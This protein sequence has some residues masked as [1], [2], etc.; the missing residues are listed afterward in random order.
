MKK[1]SKISCKFIDIS[2]PESMQMATVNFE[3]Y[4]PVDI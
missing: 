4:C 3:F 1:K 2:R